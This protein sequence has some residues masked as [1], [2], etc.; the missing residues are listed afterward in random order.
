MQPSANSNG[1]RVKCMAV[2]KGQGHLIKW[3]Q[4]PLKIGNSPP[5]PTKISGPK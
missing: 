3:G 5:L 2:Q 4:T 1:D